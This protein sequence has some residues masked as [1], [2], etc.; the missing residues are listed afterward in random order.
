MQGIGRLFQGGI[1]KH[2]E[3]DDRNEDNEKQEKLP[4]QEMGPAEH[5][6][7]RTL[8]DMERRT[9]HHLH[10][11]IGLVGVLWEDLASV[12]RFH[13]SHLLTPTKAV[14]GLRPSGS[15]RNEPRSERP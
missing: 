11:G 1:E 13:I 15:S 14:K 7:L 4:Q 5:R 9:L 10:E 3:S 8:V 12:M 2:C 6:V